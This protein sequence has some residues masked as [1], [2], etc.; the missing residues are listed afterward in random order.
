MIHVQDH[1]QRDRSIRDS[2]VGTHLPMIN[3]LVE[4]MVPQVPSYVSR[5]EIRSAAMLGLVDAAER[6][7][8][9]RGILFKTFAERRIRGAILD[10]VRRMD[11]FSRSLREKHVRISRT[12]ENLEKQLGRAPEDE[13]LAEELGVSLDAYH[14]LLCEVSRLGYISLNDSL[15]DSADNRCMI[16]NLKDESA[17]SPLAHLEETELRKEMA[18]QIRSLAE[19]ERLVIALYYH[20]ELT[21]K[22]IAGILDLS[23]G[24]VSQLH[25]QALVK[26]KSRLTR[27]AQRSAVFH[28]NEKHSACL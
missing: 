15:D 28:E 5:D 10:E 25:S 20:E 17:I 27:R 26:M 3:F 23:E 1:C 2:L 18:E 13:E 21:Q 8:P 7:D 12:R 6:F 11:W 14:D 9:G 19:K 24:R 22:E 16:D 4:R